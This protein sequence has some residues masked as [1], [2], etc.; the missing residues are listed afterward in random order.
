[1]FDHELNPVKGWWDMHALDKRVAISDQN[2]VTVVRGMVGYIDPTTSKFLVG[3]VNGS[4]PLFAFQGEN[5]FDANSDVGNISGG[6]LNT[7]VATGGY[8]L[9]TTEFVDGETYDVNTPLICGTAGDIGKVTPGTGWNAAEQVVGIVSE[10]GPRTNDHGKEV[11]KFW[12]VFIP[13]RS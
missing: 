13:D 4:M 1:M 2:G 11:V 5:D 7:L 3:G 6:Y 10:A 9:E 12:P 8:E